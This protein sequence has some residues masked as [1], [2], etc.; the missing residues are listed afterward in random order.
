MPLKTAHFRAL[1]ETYQ[2]QDRRPRPASLPSNGERN[3]ELQTRALQGFPIGTRDGRP[4][5]G[6]NRVGQAVVGRVHGFQ[7]PY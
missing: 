3:Y 4:L 1:W 2:G 5:A 7:T 6:A